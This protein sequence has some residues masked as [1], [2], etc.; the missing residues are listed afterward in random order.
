MRCS[1]EGSHWSLGSAFFRT[2]GQCCQP[3]RS[4]L[5]LADSI[6]H[7]RVTQLPNK[8]IF[9][10]R[11]QVDSTACRW[12]QTRRRSSGLRAPRAAAWHSRCDV[13]SGVSD[14]PMV[15]LFMRILGQLTLGPDG[16]HVA[17]ELLELRA[18]LHGNAKADE[19]LRT[20]PRGAARVS[21][22]HRRGTGHLAAERQGAIAAANAAAA[23]ECVRCGGGSAHRPAGERR[24]AA[25]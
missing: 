5:C 13:L 18:L 8:H 20:S 12:Q 21:C 16:L 3:S 11:L 2:A 14:V 19:R 15:I 25:L 9:N 4:L 22:C 7:A 23:V 17:Q 1:V 10:R 24:A 6:P